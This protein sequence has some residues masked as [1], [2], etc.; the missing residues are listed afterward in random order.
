MVILLPSSE[1]KVSPEWSLWSS[2]SPSCGSGLQWRV[3]DG[4]QAWRACVL[5]P[6]PSND[7]SL[8][9]EQCARH[10]KGLEDG[11]ISLYPQWE[12]SKSSDS[13]CSLDCRP[14]GRPDLVRRLNDTVMNGIICGEGALKICVAGKCEVMKLLKF[15][16]FICCEN[17]KLVVIL[18]SILV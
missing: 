9:D 3:R 16:S 7:L 6:C 5:P 10:N 4:G 12:S 15:L 1:E 8:R 18:R 11:T 17:R 13:P 2:C 14:K